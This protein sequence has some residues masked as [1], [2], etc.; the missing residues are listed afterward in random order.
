LEEYE[1]LHPFLLKKDKNEEYSNS[2]IK[3]GINNKNL[4]LLI[5]QMTFFNPRKKYLIENEIFEKNI[6]LYLTNF[7]QKK[8]L[9]YLKIFF[10]I[11]E[12]DDSN[13]NMNNTNKRKLI[14]EMLFEILV[15]LYQSYKE[16]NNLEYT[17]FESMINE[18]FQ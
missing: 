17:M 6:V 8:Q 14:I 7:L 18:L 5:Y 12:K 10:P 4:L 11:E 13:N 9:V 1:E 3:V 2:H 16:N 15:S